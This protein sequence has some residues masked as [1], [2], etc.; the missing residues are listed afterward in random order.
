MMVLN[1]FSEFC[2]ILNIQWCKQYKNI[3]YNYFILSLTNY[4]IKLKMIYMKCIQKHMN[5]FIE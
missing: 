2:P 5:L 3:F 1:Y 4:N